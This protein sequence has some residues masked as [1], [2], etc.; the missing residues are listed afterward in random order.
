MRG[1]GPRR[2]RHRAGRRTRQP[3]DGERRR[4]ARRRPDGRRRPSPRCAAR[5][6]APTWSS[7][8]RRRRSSPGSRTPSAPSGI[9]CFGPSR[10]AAALEGSKAFAKEVMAEA[11]V[12]TAMAHVCRTVDRGRGGAGRA[13]RPARGQGR[14]AR[15]RQGRRGHRRPGRGA[16]A[17]PGLPGAAA[18]T[19]RWWSRSSWT[20]P[21]SRCSASRDGVTRR[22]ARAGPGLQAAAGRRRRAEHRRHGRLLAAAVG[23]GRTWSTTSSSGSPSR[24]STRWPAAARPF[25]GLLYVGLA[26]TSRGP[27]VVEFNARFGDPETQVVLARLRV[28]ARP[29][30]CG[31]PRP[32]SWPGTRRCAGPTEAAVTVVLASPGYPASP[33]T[34]GVLRGLAA[35]DDGRRGARAARRHRPARRR[36]RLVPAGRVLSRRRHRARPGRRPRASRTTRSSRIELDGG[37]HRTDIAAQAARDARVTA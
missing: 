16:G 15:R 28:P 27:R 8:A 10:A 19:P 26:M 17:R 31:R 33:T 9:D 2:R 14:R 22:P 7:S 5:A 25:A 36:R 29:A 37:Q 30:C 11:G 6:G 13:R 21:R 12:P 20:A 35:A 23:A 32:A 18:A 4:A 34:G 24:P 3:G 1:A